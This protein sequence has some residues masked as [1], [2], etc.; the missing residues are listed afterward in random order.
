MEFNGT[1]EMIF[2]LIG[3]S[4]LILIQ[5]LVFFRISNLIKYTNKL[6][7]EVRILFKNSGIFFQPKPKSVFTYNTCQYCKNR[8][9]FIQVLDDSAT[10]NFYY[11]C[12]KR[13]MEVALSDSCE[14]FDRDV[15]LK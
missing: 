12:K 3:L 13:N 6:L 1:I 14:H 11:K 4:L 5:I 15:A 10:D 9:S 7:F 8:L 2:L